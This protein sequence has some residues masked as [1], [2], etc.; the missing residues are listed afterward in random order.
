VDKRTRRV[1]RYEAI[2]PIASG[3]MATV[4]L[5]R[6]AGDAGFSRTVA[7]KVM[8]PHLAGD[9]DFVEMFLNE[10]HLAA[11][12]RHPNV[13]ATLDVARSEEDLFLVMEYIE[14][15]TA[16]V[17][18]RTLKKQGRR[19]PHNIAVRIALDTLAGLSA[20]HELKDAEGHP[21]G[22]IH[23][24]VSPQNIIVGVA[25]IAR[26]VDFGIARAQSQATGGKGVKGKLSYMSPEQARA[27][28]IDPRT[29]VYGAGI[30]LWELLTGE[31]L[32]QADNDAGLLGLVVQGATRTPR[33]VDPTIP[34]VIDAV[35]MR[36]LSV[37]PAGRFSSAAEFAEALEDAAAKTT[38]IATPRAVAA[39][40]KEIAHARETGV[41]PRTREEDSR[42][43]ADQSS[44]PSATG[45]GATSAAHAMI[46]TGVTTRRKRS[47]K[48]AV[49]VSA[50]IGI[51][52]GGLLALLTSGPPEEGGTPAASVGDTA[53]LGA[54]QPGG[55][56][57]VPATPA[58]PQSEVADP[59]PAADEIDAK[60]G[61]SAT[62][63]KTIAPTA[64]PKKKAAPA[65]LA[66]K[67]SAPPKEQLPKPPPEVTP[68][69]QFRPG[70]L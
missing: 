63:P 32:F 35:C 2:R 22:L 23:R 27:G 46:S 42:S 21:Q 10:A 49:G 57:I 36:A 45:S 37:N 1:G 52:A 43:S 64:E 25:G 9:E 69:S 28:A 41:L 20:A 31:R 65:A 70:D 17:I 13:V 11:N 54:S 67:K 61:E 60:S 44:Q 56:T 40:L 29:D 66:P 50:V 7:L 15:L 33:Q 38:G 5:G 47:V 58:L 19:L 3:G 6:A 39:L 55:A 16:Q 68:P 24:D 30:V 48:R 51:A 59:V 18:Q 12:L 4:Y 53:H 26:L 34:P 14:G 62:G 8:H